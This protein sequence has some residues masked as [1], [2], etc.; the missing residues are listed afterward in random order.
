MTADQPLREAAYDHLAPDELA[1]ERTARAMRYRSRR[2]S[3][4]KPPEDPHT[5]GLGLDSEGYES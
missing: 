4:A 3:R 5:A 2:P 1:D